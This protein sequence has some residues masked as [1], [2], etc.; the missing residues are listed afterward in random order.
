MQR[1]RFIVVGPQRSGT[2][3]THDCLLGHHEVALTGDEVRVSPLFTRGIATFTFGNDSWEQRTRGYAA[4]FDA[5]SLID[6]RDATRVHGMKLAIGPPNDAIDLA[7]TLRAHLPDVLVV[8]VVRTDLVAQFAS[9]ES[10]QRSGVWHS[11]QGRPQL[12]RR[13]VLDPQVFLRH[14]QDTLRIHSQLARLRE[15][16]GYLEFGYERDIA[17]GNWGKLFG[18]LGIE[19]RTPDRPHYVKVARPLE[20]WITNLD[21]LREIEAGVQ[22]P[23]DATERHSATEREIESLRDE[24]SLFLLNRVTVALAAGRLDEAE[25]VAFASLDK[26]VDPRFVSPRWEF[27][28][29]ETTWQRIGSPGRARAGLARL[30]PRHHDDARFALLS[31]VVLVHCG[32]RDAGFAALARSLELDPGLDRARELLAEWRGG[33]SA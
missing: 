6:G 29:L 14:A 28:A 19:D 25:A 31:G 10:A 1:R 9:L 33:S 16:H 11:W 5:L 8:H 22:P 2:S 3:V 26:P 20:E 12:A 4:L 30:A 15:T 17:P 27:G 21:E 23:D 13:V 32:N 24:T 7:N 18:F